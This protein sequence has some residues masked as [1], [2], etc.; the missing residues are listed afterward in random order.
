MVKSKCLR[1][2]AE[3][4]NL[5]TRIGFMSYCSCQEL[6]L[7]VMFINL[8]LGLHYASTDSAASGCR[9][10]DRLSPCRSKM[11]IVRAM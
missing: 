8:T 2:F 6:R 10:M 9:S 11:R 5:K 1:T 3:I 4:R 7:A